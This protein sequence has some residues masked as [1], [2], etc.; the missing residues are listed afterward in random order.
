MTKLKQCPHCGGDGAEPNGKREMVVVGEMILGVTTEEC[1]I[2]NGDGKVT[3][4]DFNRYYDE[5]W[6]SLVEFSIDLD[7]VTV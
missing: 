2:C 6:P 4:A 7:M 3:E 1:H 5:L